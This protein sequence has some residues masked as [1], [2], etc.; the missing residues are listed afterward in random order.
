MVTME[1]AEYDLCTFYLA[2][3]Q[4]PPF[5][6]T[7]FKR[8]LS[9]LVPTSLFAYGGPPLSWNAHQTMPTDGFCYG[10]LW[11]QCKLLL[12]GAENPA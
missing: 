9:V 2:R 12:K 11:V 8:P 5:S 3:L 10:D 7:S 1:P 4:M 6:S